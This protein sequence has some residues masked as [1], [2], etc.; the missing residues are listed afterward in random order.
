MLPAQHNTPISIISLI[1]HFEIIFPAAI[2]ES[3]MEN[4]PIVIVR[5]NA[6]LDMPRSAAT[7]FTYTPMQLMHVA[8]MTLIIRK[9]VQTMSH[10]LTLFFTRHPY[11]L[12]IFSGVSVL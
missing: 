4:D 12:L 8:N 9:E 2:D 1:F 11:L 10:A 6:V 3:I 5:E 7:G